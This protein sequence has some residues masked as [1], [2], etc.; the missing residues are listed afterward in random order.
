MVEFDDEDE[1]DMGFSQEKEIIK[2][3]KRSYDIDFSVYSPGDIQSYQDKQIDEVSQ[4][5]GQPPEACAI[6]L[7][8]FR[9]NKE[10]LIETY[11]DKPETILENAGLGAGSGQ[12]PK[13]T[14]LKT[15]TCGICF[16]NEPGTET[17]ALKCSHR[18]CVD[19]YQQYLAQKIQNEQ[20]AAWIQCPTEGCKQIVDSKSMDLLVAADLKSRYA[21]KSPVREHPLITF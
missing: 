3:S 21:V 2:P 17:Y 10:R 15:F 12:L 5:L 19:C 11:M 18:Y 4:I 8:H 13:T 14:A 1:P 6:L 7:R 9:W 16:D 20:E